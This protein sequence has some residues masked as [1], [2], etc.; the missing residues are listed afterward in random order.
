M[1]PGNFWTGISSIYH[2][3]MTSSLDSFSSFWSF[4]SFCSPG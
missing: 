2:G 4:H 3:I 1:Q